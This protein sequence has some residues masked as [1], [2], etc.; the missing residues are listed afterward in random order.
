MLMI[1]VSDVIP[2]KKKVKNKTGNKR[3]K[4]KLMKWEKI[5]AKS[6]I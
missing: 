5:F 3:V 2:V 1:W 4:R 6:C